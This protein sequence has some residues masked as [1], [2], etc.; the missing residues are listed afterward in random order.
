[1]SPSNVSGLVRRETRTVGALLRWAVRRP[2]TP[3]GARR[4]TYHSQLRPLLIALLPVSVLELVVVELLVPW[5]P[6][7]VVLLV[8]SAYFVLWLLGLIASMTVRPHWIDADRLAL[9][10]MTFGSLTVPLGGRVAAR[11]I[12]VGGRRRNVEV[13]DDELTVSVMGSANVELEFDQPVAVGG[14]LACRVRRVRFYADRPRDAIE[15]L[16]RG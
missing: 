12:R 13:D 3:A 2:L 16:L 11:S 15:A 4:L 9:N 10:C 14:D 8:V 1:M 7:R 5:A 6:V